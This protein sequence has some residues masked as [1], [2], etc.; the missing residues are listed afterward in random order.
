MICHFT[1]PTTLETKENF[2]NNLLGKNR[3]NPRPN[4]LN[5]LEDTKQPGQ[6]FFGLADFGHGQADFG[7]NLLLG[8]FGPLLV[9]P[10]RLWPTLATRLGLAD[11]WWPGRFGPTDPPVPRTP[12]APDR[13]PPDRP[14]F[15]VFFP[16][17]RPHFH[18]FCLSGCLLVSFFFSLGVLS[19]NFGGVLVG[20]VPQMCLFST[21][22][23]TACKSPRFHTTCH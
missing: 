2:R 3:N 17:P 16:S 12:S 1:P 13:P 15:R 18:S 8:Q 7:H 10:G 19:W 22:G 9:G 21:S 20:R 4:I 6:A 5:Q 14:T 23:W 11:F